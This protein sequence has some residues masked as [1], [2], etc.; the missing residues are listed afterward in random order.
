MS[1]E[2]AD[3]RIE[4]L[5]AKHVTQF[6][7]SSSPS[8]IHSTAIILQ[9]VGQ[10]VV[11]QQLF[12][13]KPAT[14]EDIEYESALLKL[15]VRPEDVI[16]S[17]PGCLKCKVLF[18]SSRCVQDH[19]RVCDNVSCSTSCCPHLCCPLARCE[20]CKRN[21]CRNC[22]FWC[23]LCQTTQHLDCAR[24]RST[25]AGDIV[26]FIT[27]HPHFDSDDPVW[28]CADHKLQLKPMSERYSTFRGRGGR[29][30]FRSRGR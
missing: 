6:L 22:G 23:E 11:C 13:P 1:R 8:L 18:C 21:I 4:R 2:L 16:A 19:Q 28:H 30:S 3:D 25:C 5:D 15:G 14:Q 10:C 27:E 26:G 17:L 12:Y 24:Y 20:T 7:L 29:G 9:Y